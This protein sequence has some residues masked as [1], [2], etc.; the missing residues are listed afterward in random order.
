MGFL[1]KVGFWQRNGD[2][3]E[4]AHSQVSCRYFESQPRKV[5]PPLLQL[6]E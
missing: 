2:P 5:F 6:K 4:F 1:R 3:D